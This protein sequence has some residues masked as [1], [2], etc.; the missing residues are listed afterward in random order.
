MCNF[1][2]QTHVTLKRS[3]SW[4]RHGCKDSLEIVIE[5]VSS[6]ILKEESRVADDVKFARNSSLWSHERNIQRWKLIKK[7]W[8]KHNVQFY[9]SNMWSWKGSRS[10][11][12]FLQ[13]GCHIGHGHQNCYEWVEF[14]GGYNHAKTERSCWCNVTKKST[15]TFWFLWRQKMCQ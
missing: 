7:L 1:T 8:R 11:P 4:N 5:W 3:R 13:Y 9:F 10:W 14:N 12:V 15:K 6:A 2:F